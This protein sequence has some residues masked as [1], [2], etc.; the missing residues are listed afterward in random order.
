MEC[1]HG[2]LE[3][4]A[5]AVRSVS[6]ETIGFPH[7]AQVARLERTRVHGRTGAKTHEVVWLVTSLTAE[8]A[9]PE[10]LLALARAYWG[11]ENGA[12]QRLDVSADEDRCRVRH[13]VA[14]LVLGWLRRA[15]L[16]EYAAWA[17]RQ[18]RARDATLPLYFAEQRAKI[19]RAID[20]IT[21]TL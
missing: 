11:I 15:V 17:R 12:H 10:R 3:R 13:P 19:N 18:R 8:Q 9:G 14:G 6:A 16:G 5:V 2:H 4:R 20:L 21:S 1:N 7:A